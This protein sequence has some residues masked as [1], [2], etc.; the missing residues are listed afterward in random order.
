[1]ATGFGYQRERRAWQASLLPEIIPAV[2]DIRRNGA[3]SLD[4]C[5][6]AGGRFDA[7]YEWGLSPWD[8]SAGR[9]ICTEAG[10]SVEILPGHIIVAAVPSLAQPLA[11]LLVE[12]G[13]GHP[14][15]TPAVGIDG[16]PTAS[17]SNPHG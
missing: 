5:W 2:R 13:R 12:A 3:A 10:A 7:Y 1:M 15:P 8:L 14:A 4:L 11:E 6:V 16:V 9:L 17:G